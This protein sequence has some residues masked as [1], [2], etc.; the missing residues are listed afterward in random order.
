MKATVFH[1]LM[2]QKY[3]NSKQ[4][5]QISKD[6]TVNNIK[7]TGLN[8]YVYNNSNIINIYEYLMKKHDIK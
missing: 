3:F 7:K 4:K 5:T 1:L 8:G 6:F 2:P